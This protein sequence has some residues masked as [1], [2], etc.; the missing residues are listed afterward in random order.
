MEKTVKQN[1][2]NNPRLRNKLI[3]YVVMLALPFI[4]LC[5][6]YV[7]VNFSTIYMSFFK[8]TE[9]VGVLGYE[10]SFAFPENFVHVWNEIIVKHAWMIGNSAKFYAIDFPIALTLQLTFSYYIYK[11]YPMAGFFKIILYMPSLISGLVFSILFSRLMYDG[12]MEIRSIID[13]GDT[14]HAADYEGFLYDERTCMFGVIFFNIWCSFG[15]NILMYSGAM[16]GIDE[17]I[18][19]SCHLDGCNLLQEFWH[20]SVP[21]IF[22]TLVAL[23]I[24]SITGIFNNQMGLLSLYGEQLSG[25]S[26]VAVRK[27][28]TIGF[29]MYIYTKQITDL[30]NQ[31]YGGVEHTPTQLCAYG[32]CVTAVVIPIVFGVKALL[33]KYGPS[34]D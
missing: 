29:R 4:Q 1:I 30:R 20:I 3:F 11:K 17:S 2:F 32:V 24:T 14:T 15:V 10:M 34:V 13:F 5:L 16:S 22:P 9:R 27:V 28:N 21:L 18:V 31:V 8:M 7:Y 23:T 25:L 6:F 12:Y 33:K 19:E 26:Q